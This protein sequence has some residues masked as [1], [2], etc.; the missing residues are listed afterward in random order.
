MGQFMTLLVDMRLGGLASRLV[1]F[2]L[3]LA[4]LT[5]TVAGQAEFN[6]VLLQ[7][8]DI[9]L[10][11]SPSILSVIYA[12]YGNPPG[13]YS[14]A[15]VFFYDPQGRPKIMH[16]RT[17]PGISDLRSF[18]QDYWQI[19]VLR[20][21][22]DEAQRRR[23]GETLCAWSQ[24]T[25]ILKATFDYKMQDVPG[26]RDQ[27]YCIGFLNEIWRSCDL[28]PP[29]ALGEKNEPT[30]IKSFV[31]QEFGI[32]LD[33]VTTASSILQNQEFSQLTEWSDHSWSAHDQFLLKQVL[34]TMET[35]VKAGYYGRGMGPL[36]GWIISTVLRRKGYEANAAQALRMMNQASAFHQKVYG[37]YR[38]FERRGQA[39]EPC[40]ED[41]AELIRRICDYYRD[42]Y[43]E[44]TR[45][46]LPDGTLCPAGAAAGQ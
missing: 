37:R 46:V 22:L 8:G 7:D 10:T 23:L 9:F 3:I 5:M 43:F 24:D 44:K 17:S 39:P 26:R 20:G 27:F 19:A 38:L 35:Y 32:D 11:Q 4:G 12:R 18:P 6:G 21:K 40:S 45:Q 2:Y 30:I 33:N 16:V 34:A 29:F 41:A 36:Q 1:A 31:K 42:D 25:A 13:D 15:G 28:Q 14:H